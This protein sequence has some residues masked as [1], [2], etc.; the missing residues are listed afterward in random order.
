MVSLLPTCNDK[1]FI[2]FDT[3]TTLI[4]RFPGF[5]KTLQEILA[6]FVCTRRV[7][8]HS[9]TIHASKLFLIQKM[10]INMSGFRPAKH[11]SR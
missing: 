3:T 1:A 11:P 5:P 6:V 8:R 10:G 9:A 4:R 7:Q 2:I